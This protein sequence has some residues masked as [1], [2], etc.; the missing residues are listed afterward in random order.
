[1][2]IV[3]DYDVR[4]NLFCSPTHN[5]LLDFVPDNTIPGDQKY[6]LG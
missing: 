6:D 1:M 3:V 4:F 5:Q 2:D